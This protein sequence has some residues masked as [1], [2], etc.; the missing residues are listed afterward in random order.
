MRVTFDPGS[1]L[2]AAAL[3]LREVAPPRD[4]AALDR[5]IAE[6]E[7]R[8]RGAVALEALGQ[9]PRVQALRQAFRGAGVDPSRYRPSSEALARR[10]LRGDPLPRINPLVDL[11]N[12]CSVE[13]MLP[14]GSYD[15]SRIEGD[16]VL[17]PGAPGE[18]YE[19]IGKTLAVEGKPV[20]ADDAGAFGSPISDSRRT[21]VTE[22][23]TE[24]LVIAYSPRDV[25]PDLLLGA[26][27]RLAGLA[28]ELLDA[29]P[30]APVL[31]EAA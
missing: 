20:A 12:A 30:E 4:P 16:V 10:V 5:L 29:R 26:L 9:D 18:T 11:N 21:L 13:A 2:T 1:S 31:A 3:R 28:R 23:T 6:T 25:E 15:A 24:V 27:T 14:F 8:L 7:Q 22:T 19:A 17:R